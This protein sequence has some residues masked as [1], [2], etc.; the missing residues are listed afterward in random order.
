MENIAT[1][2]SKL[3][4]RKG[5][6]KNYNKDVQKNNALENL[7]PVHPHT[8]EGCIIQELL[9]LRMADILKEVSYICSPQC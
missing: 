5:D 1:T 4:T 6:K 7:I 3:L 2:W 8:A 9:P